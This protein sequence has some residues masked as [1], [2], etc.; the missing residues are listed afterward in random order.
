MELNK[1]TV[2][3]LMGLIAFAL[4]LAIVLQNLPTVWNV[5]GTAINIFFPFILG[6]CIAF[7]LNIPMDVI[8]RHLFSAKRRQQKWQ[9]AIARP[10]SLV[11]AFLLV[12][13]LIAIVGLIIVPEIGRT[14][15]TL[16]NNISSFIGS[17]QTNLDNLAQE[18]SAIANQLMNI[19]FD[20]QNIEGTLIEFARNSAVAALNTSI[21]AIAQIAGGV[22]NFFIG[23]VF[24]I[25]VL[26]QKEKLGQQCR[27]VLYAF[28]PEKG[29]DKF[30]EILALASRTFS[31]FVT[32]QCTEAVILGTIFFVVL[33]ILRFPYGLLIGV[34]IAALAL[35]P[36]FGAF[37]GCIV[38]ALLILTV[39]PLQALIFII[40]FLVIQQ[41]EGNL[42]YPHVVGSSVGLPSIWVLV[43]VT[44]GGSAFG[45]VGMIVI[46][47]LCSV[48]YALLKET[49][50]K[51][52]A[53][54]HVEAG[55]LQLTTPEDRLEARKKNKA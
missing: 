15:V 53:K 39:N 17:L 42:I 43:A 26:L 23:L 20:W 5:I 7:I 49:V 25:Y 4:L 10:V 52:L 31:N 46:I 44:V 50:G 16:A 38:G 18:H 28:L 12:I 54:R 14:F 30:L 47:P 2:K 48:C 40:L 45:I 36:I 51:R 33:T 32:G 19:N 1:R 24:A 13:A 3:I 27:K 6:G 22:V 11:L 55:K 37:V 9:R 35:I 41:I 29:V 21:S 8:E 34:M